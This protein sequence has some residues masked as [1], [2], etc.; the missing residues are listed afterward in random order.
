[1]MQLPPYARTLGI[2][3]HED[4]DPDVAPH[5]RLPPADHLMGRPGFLHGGALSGLLE[6][7]GILAARQAFG[8]AYVAI[9]PIGM[10]VDF[11]RGARFVPTFARGLLV[12][13]GARITAVAVH[14]WQDDETRPVATARMNLSL[15]R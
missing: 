2:L 5:L 15:A 1:M 9:K 4:D 11:L 8:D 6:M 12:R 10:T 13:N 3:I 14:A 7:A